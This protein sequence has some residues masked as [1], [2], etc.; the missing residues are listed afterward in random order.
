MV[1]APLLGLPGCAPAPAPVTE[2]AS[3]GPFIKLSP[4]PPRAHGS[5]A[6]R[7]AKPDLPPERKEA[8]FKQFS[9]ELAGDPGLHSAGGPP[10]A[11]VD[12]CKQAAR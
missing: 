7:L 12:A 11:P 1:V 9:A 6:C 3:P 8:L 5:S 4:R 2:A 10:A